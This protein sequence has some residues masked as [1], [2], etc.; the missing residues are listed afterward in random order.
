MGS[1]GALDGAQA[2]D[3]LENFIGRIDETIWILNNVD[4]MDAWKTDELFA[5]ILMHDC[6]S[7]T[8]III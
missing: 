5:D 7:T 1:Y 3:A 4:N 8:V 6:F 2:E